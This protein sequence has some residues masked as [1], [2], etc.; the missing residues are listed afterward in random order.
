MIPERKRPGRISKYLKPIQ[1]V[2]AGKKPYIPFKR[3]CDADNC[4]TYF[5]GHF[6]SQGKAYVRSE[7]GSSRVYI[8]KEKAE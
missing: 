1:S 6:S 7:N 8:E 2:L 4:A 3:R 5:R